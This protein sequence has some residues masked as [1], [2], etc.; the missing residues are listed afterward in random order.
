MESFESG[1]S[2]Y[3]K[4]LGS[5][6]RSSSSWVLWDPQ[7]VPSHNPWCTVLTILILFLVILG[8]LAVAGLA[9]YMGALRLE[10]TQSYLIF[11]GSMRVT[12]DRYNNNLANKTTHFFLE[13]TRKYQTLLEAVYS[14]SL[15]GPS[16]HQLFI[17]SFANGSLIVFFRIILDRRK[18]PKPISSIE[19]I[20]KTVIIQ[21]ASSPLSIMNTLKI[22][23]K[24]ILIKRFIEDPKYTAK[25]DFPLR[26]IPDQDYQENSTKIISLE[27]KKIEKSDLANLNG[28]S[29][30]ISTNNSS[31]KA[32][33]KTLPSQMIQGSYLVTSGDKVKT[34]K[35]SAK[36][37]DLLRNP[38]L[39]VPSKRITNATIKSTTTSDKPTTEMQINKGSM[40]LSMKHSP[41]LKHYLQ[42]SKDSSTTTKSH[43]A[44]Q[45]DQDDA[46]T[47]PMPKI[48][49]AHYSDEP[50]KP[51]IPEILQS[52]RNFNEKIDFDYGIGEAEVVLDS[53]SDVNVTIGENVARM[54]TR[55]IP[56]ENQEDTTQI[57]IDN[58]KNTTTTPRPKVVFREDLINE[59]KSMP[60]L[61]I[62]KQFHDLDTLLK[63]QTVKPDLIEGKRTTV[64]TLLPV[65]SNVGVRPNLRPRPKDELPVAPEST[66]VKMDLSVLN[67][68]QATTTSGTALNISAES[69]QNRKLQYPEAEMVAIPLQKYFTSTNPPFIK[70]KEIPTPPPIYNSNDKISSYVTENLKDIAL[71]KSDTVDTTV[72]R[73]E[74]QSV[75]NS[76]NTYNA[77]I[78]RKPKMPD[79]NKASQERS[80]LDRFLKQRPIDDDM[81][82]LLEEI[83]FNLTTTARTERQENK[84]R[85]DLKK[86]YNLPLK[87]NFNLSPTLFPANSTPKSPFN[88]NATQ[89]IL[90]KLAKLQIATSES[91]TNHSHNIKGVKVSNK[92]IATSFPGNDGGFKILTKTFNKIPP[93]EGK[94]RQN[95][96]EMPLFKSPECVQNDSML[97]GSGECIPVHLRCN[98]LWDCH[99]GT[100][101]TNCTCADFLKNQFHTRKICDGIFDCWDY[102]DEQNCDWC[103]PGQYVC[104]NSRMCIDQSQIC[105]GFPHCPYGDDEKNC[106]TLAPSLEMAN[107][108]NYYPEGYLMVRKEGEWGKM[109]MQSFDNVISKSKT[110]WS[111]DDLGESVCKSLTYRHF[112]NITKQKDESARNVANTPI[113]YEL[114]YNDDN[115]DTFNNRRSSSRDK[116]SFQKTTCIEE[117]VAQVACSDLECG[118]R[119]EAT[120]PWANER[121]S[122]IVGGGNAGPGSW[123]WQAALYKEGEFQCG[124]TLISDSWLLSAGHCFYHAQDDY[125][126]ARLGALRRGTPPAPYEQLR[127]ISSIVLHPEYEDVGFVNDISLLRLHEPVILS[128]FVRPICL[129]QPT[130]VL[131]DGTMCTVVGWGQLF[132]IGRV[133][134]DTLQEVQ[135]PIIST[136]ECRKRTL[137]LPL[138]KVTDNMFCAGYE[139]GGRDACLGDSGGPLMCQ[140]S[141]GRWTLTGVTSNGYGCARANRPGVYTKVVNYLFWVNEVMRRDEPA[142]GPPPCHGHRCPL[143]ECLPPARLCNGY[144]ECRDSSDEW[145]CTG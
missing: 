90:N 27:R 81:K 88:L 139:R 29:P 101:E 54:K 1:I 45:I 124:A 119:P 93:E 95:S 78:N 61:S 6:T 72:H 130:Q 89:Y 74:W 87:I 46:I 86:T 142:Y 135:L 9:L 109:C 145:D 104:G 121:R 128:S 21:E 105:D 80:S 103:T 120:I 59:Q 60:E 96:T 44:V 2:R 107:D 26:Y 23:P 108:K 8:V 68:T 118:I 111:I 102:S 25:E 51:L 53:Y 16:L 77:Y 117:E 116:F 69:D 32:I 122:R 48:T 52:K 50:W 134:P 64:V 94:K 12:G 63:T 35:V 4:Q 127:P 55:P 38:S 10:P 31:E 106:I 144:I 136:G 13:K 36:E 138:Y 24:E 49:N 42:L 137:F 143:G 115:N 65:R 3:G 15:L 73:N 37:D 113:Y 43:P 76:N 19:D 83:F 98:K 125:W 11:D 131:K 75:S 114:S 58:V 57:P 82:L 28:S 92:A 18:I 47:S 22:D 133:F 141:D 140:E 5:T 33:I 66:N 17:T 91:I 7:T 129:P 126:V 39:V 79:V 85:T 14:K 62:L 132:E 20:L 41:I 71:I 70:K 112:N 97:C 67:P 30:E 84:S 100:D 110:D 56:L 123:P 34:K 99:D 40:L